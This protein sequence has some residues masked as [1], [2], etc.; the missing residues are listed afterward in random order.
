V[1]SIATP[2]TSATSSNGRRTASE[3][4]A[5]SPAAVPIWENAVIA[6]R[7]IATPSGHRRR[8]QSAQQPRTP[9]TRSTNTNHPGRFTSSAA[10]PSKTI[11]VNSANTKSAVSTIQSRVV[12]RG[13]W[14]GSP[15]TPEG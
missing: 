10:M 4:R 7:P 13:A 2:A 11:P 8:S 12:R 6:S 5:I 9:H 14:S 3:N 1:T 15:F